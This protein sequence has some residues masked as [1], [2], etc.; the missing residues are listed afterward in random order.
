M[1]K[2][3]EEQILELI[4]NDYK[5]RKK[6]ILAPV[7]RSRKGQYREMFEQIRKKGYLNV[8]VDG[9][10]EEVRHGMKLDRY[11]MHDIEIVI[12]KMIVTGS[13]HQRLKDS[14]RVAMKQGD[15]LILLLDADTGDTR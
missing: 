13:E 11:K 6:Y 5:E 12:D 4:L 14:L 1:V 7:V 15:G 8:R 10:L 9:K 3:T 2:Y